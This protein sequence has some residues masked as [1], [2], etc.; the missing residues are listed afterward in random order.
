MIDDRG[1]QDRPGTGS[2]G[3][4]SEVGG[5][6]SA[7]AHAV[8]FPPPGVRV[9]PVRYLHRA[10]AV[11]VIQ[12]YHESFPAAQ[13]IADEALLR[14]VPEPQEEPGASLFYVAEDARQSIGFAAGVHVTSMRLAYLA[15]MAISPEWRDRG[16]GSALLRAL[17]E[18]W[19]RLR[20][21]PPH[22]LFMEVERPELGGNEE[23]RRQRQRRIAFYESHG[24]QRLNAD[25]QAPPIGPEL[26]IVPYSILMLPMFEPD[27]RLP[28]LRVALADLYR[29]VYGLPEDNP[30]V[31]NCLQS[32]K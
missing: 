29:E 17:V 9:R 11:A 25:F 2:E 1:E 16:V 7:A 28:A 4:D 31:V 27:L 18:C 32:M 6:S 23:E 22:W 14:F 30:L 26:L 3:G 21:K 24:C 8:Q 20:P 19:F 15:Y 12:I 13:R 10:E 5:V